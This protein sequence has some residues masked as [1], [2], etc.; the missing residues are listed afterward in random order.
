[1][2]N[3]GQFT[4]GAI[5]TAAELNAFTP[6]TVLTQTGTQLVSSAT[7]TAV[8]FDSETEDTLNW[9][10][11]SVN[12]TRVTPTIAGYYLATFTGVTNTTT[13]RNISQISKNGTLVAKTDVSATTT[14]LNISHMVFCNGTTDY[15][16][17]VLYQQ[18][19]TA[20]NTGPSFFSV[21][22][23]RAT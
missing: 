19:G 3:Q 20:V 10:S 15:L 5:L 13:T 18:N 22:L 16:E 14:A 8:Q 21:M 23:V 9:H 11:N 2:A 17:A 12:N 4:T 1:M 6:I 7:F